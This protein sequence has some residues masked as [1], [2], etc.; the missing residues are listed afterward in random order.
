MNK[1]DDNED[2]MPKT[3]S[4]ALVFI[5]CSLGVFAFRIMVVVFIWIVAFHYL[6]KWLV[7]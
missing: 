2:N 4:E 6:E 7:K 5:A 3:L 1:H